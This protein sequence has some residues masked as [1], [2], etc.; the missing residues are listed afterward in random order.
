MPR[1]SGTATYRKNEIRLARTLGLPVSQLTKNARARALERTGL[2]LRESRSLKGM[3]SKIHPGAVVT[4][5]KGEKIESA[6]RRLRGNK[7]PRPPFQGGPQERNW[8]Y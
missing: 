1:K 8:E 4:V 2:R 5:M 7:K 6:Q 3:H